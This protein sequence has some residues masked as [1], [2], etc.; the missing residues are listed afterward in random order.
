MKTE[1]IR[2]P[3]SDVCNARTKTETAEYRNYVSVDRPASPS[4]PTTPTEKKTRSMLFDGGWVM[5]CTRLFQRQRTYI[6]CMPTHALEHL[7]GI[8][9]GGVG[10]GGSGDTGSHIARTRPT[11][12]RTCARTGEH[13]RYMRTCWAG[14]A[15]VNGR[16]SLRYSNVR[17]NNMFGCVATDDWRQLS[18]VAFDSHR[19]QSR[20]SCYPPPHSHLKN[21]CDM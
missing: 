8:F 18:P 13:V 9:H 12:T 19:S 10:S 14:H 4:S 3:E 7:L 1:S 21:K 5:F 11:C 20:S 15:G 17:A 16:K 2:T 6:E